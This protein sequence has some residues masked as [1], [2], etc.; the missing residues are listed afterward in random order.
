VEICGRSPDVGESIGDRAPD[1]LVGVGILEFE[2]TDDFRSCLIAIFGTC[3][4]VL[5]GSGVIWESMVYVEWKSNV[6]SSCSGVA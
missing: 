6:V 2:M 4:E 3:M 1:M 5:I